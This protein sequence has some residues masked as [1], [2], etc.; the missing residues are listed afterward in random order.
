MR[1]RALAW[2]VGVSAAYFILAALLP[3][4]E[5]TESAAVDP[6][7]LVPETTTSAIV[8]APAKAEPSDCA[9]GEAGHDKP[10][11]D[12]GLD[13]K[14]LLTKF[15]AAVQRTK[16]AVHTVVE[17]AGVPAVEGQ[18][19]LGFSGPRLELDALCKRHGLTVVRAASDH[20]LLRSNAPVAPLLATLRGEAGVRYAEPN[21]V[22]SMA[23]IPNDP[24]LAVTGSKSAALERAWDVTT[25]SPAI[26]VAVLD[27][28]VDDT[29][30]DLR[31][32]LVP[33]FDFVNNTAQN[34]DDN[35]H[36]T[37]MI[38][39][40]A[41]EGQN[42][43]GV[44]GVAFNARV[45]PIKVADAL[46]QA[47]VADVVAGIDFAIVNNARVINLS[48][49]AP[50]GSQALEDAINRALA[51]GLVVVASAGNDPVHHEAFPA[52]YDGV[53]SV[54][55][56][57]SD[58]KLGF[59]AAL[60]EGIDVG[61]VGESIV[62][63]LPGEVYG[64]V[65][66]T[67]ASA[68]YVSGVAA[69]CAS[70]TPTLTGAQLRQI[71]R[72]AQTTIPE[73]A[74]AGTT[75][76]FGALDPE[77]AVLRATG[78]YLDIAVTDLQMLPQK[79]IPGQPGEAIVELT[80]EGNVALTN[81][82]VRV[83][84][85]LAGTTN[86]IEIGFRVVNL[87]VGERT[88]LRLPFTTPTA[89]TY[90]INAIA[91]TIPGETE[92]ADNTRVIPA[93]VINPFAQVDLRIVA[94]RISAPVASAGT[95]T[96][97]VDVLNLGTAPAQNVVV[98]ADVS[99]AG[100]TA[101]APAAVVAAGAGGLGTQTIP[102]I[103]VGQ[104]ATVQFTYTVPN[105]V[106]A[107][108]QRLRVHSQP[109][110]NEFARTDNTAFLDFQ[111]GS[112]QSLRGLYQQS[113]GVDL[114]ADAP[115][116]V[117]PTRPYLPVQVFVASKGG[118]TNT[119]KL[120]VNRVGVSVANSPSGPWSLV[121]HDSYG[122]APVNAPPGMEIATEM[123]VIRSTDLDLFSDN[124]LDMNGRHEILRIP[125]DALGAAASP[126]QGITKYVDVEVEW[127][128][129]RVVLWLFRKTRSGDTKS[130][131]RVHFAADEMPSLPGDNHYHDVH[132]HT[133][134][135]WY[136]GSAL[137]IFA[138]RKAYGGPLQMVFESAYA[139]GFITDATQA[140]AYERII[141]TD[142][143]SFNN[144]TTPAPDGADHRPP[145]GPQ[146]PS[147]QPGM[148]QLEAYRAIF[149]R[150]AGEE[151]AFKQDIPLPRI[152][153]VNKILNMLPGIPLGAHMLV[154]ESDH[155]E[156]PWHG[157]G[158]LKSPGNP[159]IDVNLFPTLNDLAKNRQGS[160]SGSFAYAAHPFSG[161]GW[162]DSNL[163]L[164]F[165]LDPQ[166][167]TE[168]AV[169]DQSKEFILKGVE[170]FNGRGTRSLPTSQIDFNNL[171]PWIDPDFQRGEADWDKGLWDGVTIWQ[172]ALADTLSYS[173]TND[174]DVRL[175]RKIYHAGG[176]DAHGD[177][178]FSTGRAATP[179]NLQATF[180]VGDE[181]WYKVRTYCFGETKQ[182]ATLEERWF[183][184]YRDGNSVVSDGP[185]V[186]F[187]LD[188]QPQF[189]SRSMTWHAGAASFENTDGRIGGAG[190][191]DGGHTALVEKG[192]LS[193]YF[194]YR[195]SSNE[196]FGPVASILLYKTEAGAV[197][198]VRNRP[199]GFL[200][201]SS[202]DQITGVNEFALSGKDTWLHH[203]FDGS[204]EGPVTKATA[205][206]LGAYTGGNPDQADLGP[207]S[208]RCW[209]NPIFAVPYEVVIDPPQVD[210]VAGVIPAGTL[211]VT[212]R[213]DISMDPGSYRIHLKAIDATGTSS[214]S[215]TAPETALV[216][217]SGSGWSDQPGI[218]SSEITLTNADAIPLGGEEYP[219]A[220]GETS[221]VVYWLDAPR[222]YAGN[223]LN[224]IAKSF[225]ADHV[226]GGPSPTSLP[227]ASPP[228]PGGSTT[229]PASSSTGT[230]A[231]GSTGTSGSGGG[232]NSGGLCSV[233]AESPSMP[234]TAW[235]LL[236]VLAVLVIRRRI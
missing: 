161:Q 18:V 74:P 102:L 96:V 126:A 114:I 93:L 224:S 168:D 156:G 72:E 112:S 5:R 153:F 128:S 233:S 213:F 22:A 122:A 136:F 46:G 125:R 83:E 199:S 204:K 65:T 45:M 184:A 143:S 172:K 34:S 27:T 49:G 193:P 58:G 17:I 90:R 177:F 174:P 191:Y 78:A 188:T 87:A 167:R 60:A 116:R 115:W 68:A 219:S 201:M 196:E 42:N 206:T 124:E 30:P 109:L 118:R 134:A 3:A 67:S 62:T 175:I 135:E 187:E 39:I 119:S 129:Q 189:D 23:L 173:F 59:D 148:T 208:F 47:S 192:S 95:I 217:L 75:Y 57:G 8:E 130:V 86:R 194:R 28:G 197:N 111:I 181:A 92:I 31:N 1:R 216:A 230:T 43:E 226:P 7:P 25:G 171:N 229:A 69:L 35:G 140:A 214:S 154:Y 120:R 48:M 10:G 180:N 121:Y 142:H 97:E 218:K 190:A 231:A 144:R 160:Q 215:T 182:G 205:F 207:D 70:R 117:A 232:G 73:L 123:G 221:F 132:N 101:V 166:N 88:V 223:T 61:A 139:M 16:G 186:T 15:R 235:L 26:V 209:T 63:T 4:P 159:N 106:P 36:G 212:F 41:A 202:Y 151:I 195:Y 12:C 107:G 138:P 104:Q 165:G 13:A 228:T 64:F 54:T 21:L 163:R 157:G 84:R 32:R 91:S 2:G 85:I 155:I 19:L 222:D 178:N 137:D 234:D 33:G 14:T 66:G 11:H 211:R 227:V 79:P 44:V 176:S 81:R 103:G 133:I 29:H 6:G 56:L 164:G 50:V 113:N 80:N 76:R 55:A 105:P 38:G 203:A 169:H 170:F 158:W 141:T 94:R 152:P 99:L 185:L 150:T 236:G 9:H 20:A 71:L 147:A 179:L 183:A 100:P 53:I 225:S 77:K 89:G 146:S 98:Q 162:N 127:E 108:I 149:G 37:A 51:A 52:A 198:P 131:L 40:V 210:L 24:F 82:V 220:S 110:L 200:G 145:F